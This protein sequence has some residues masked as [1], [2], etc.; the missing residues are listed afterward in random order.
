MTSLPL[1]PP[2]QPGNRR[3]ADVEQRRDRALRVAGVELAQCLGLLVGVRALLRPN[4]TPRA[5][6]WLRP[7][8]VRSVTR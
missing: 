7:A 5:L 4:F 3:L 2:L 1:W 6:A 8:L